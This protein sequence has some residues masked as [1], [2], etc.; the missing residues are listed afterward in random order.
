MPIA[1][2]HLVLPFDEGLDEG[3]GEEMHAEQTVT[4]ITTTARFLSRYSGDAATFPDSLI[5]RLILI[6]RHDLVYTQGAVLRGRL[7]GGLWDTLR[8]LIRPLQNCCNTVS[9]PLSYR[10]SQGKPPLGKRAATV[11][12]QL[13]PFILTLCGAVLDMTQGERV[14]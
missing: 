13:T 3:L 5:T 14:G 1:L 7:S 6:M 4:R 12:C 11:F 2:E 10:L 9:G 8:E